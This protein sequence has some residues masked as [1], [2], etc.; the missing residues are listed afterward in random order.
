[1]TCLRDILIFALCI[2]LALAPVVS[3][4]SGPMTWEGSV[5]TGSLVVKENS[6][7]VAEKEVLTFDI[8][9]FP[10]EYYSTESALQEYYGAT[11]T[12]EYTFRNP[13]DADVTA[14][15]LFPYGLMPD[16][17]NVYAE[18][19]AGAMEFVES[20]CGVWADGEPL[21]VLRRASLHGPGED[22]DISEAERLHGSFMDHEFY[23][24]D[25]TVTKYLY[26]VSGVDHETYGAADWG[27][28]LRSDPAL[29]KILIRD[30]DGWGTMEDHVLVHG[31]VDRRTETDK[32][33][34]HVIG[35]PFE[36]QPEW[37]VYENGACEKVIDGTVELIHTETMTLLE[38][39]T[40]LWQDRYGISVTDWYNAFIQ[41]LSRREFS[42]GCIEPDVISR[43]DLASMYWYQYELTIPAGE[44]VVNTVTAP[45]YPDI[46]KGW[47]PAIYTYQYLLSPAKGWADFGS[48]DIV[49]KT[50]YYMTQCNLDGFEKT[51]EGYTL[52]LEGLPDK[53]LE[54]VLCYEQDP[55]R[56]G[57]RGDRM[58]LFAGAA[59]AVLIGGLLVRMGKRGKQNR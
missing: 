30:A 7:I 46:H 41:D 20:L 48:L 5:G 44:T 26:E 8:R 1:M 43:V 52:H 13:T 28:E 57:S 42:Q 38:L 39:S 6:P 35:E 34:V 55:A 50:P 17:V 47:D 9:Q 18:E 45:L 11:V 4:N 31:G 54:F 12:A 56:P 23:R 21:E 16:Y 51:A 37:V 58:L 36:A 3:A 14:T 24:P 59:A 53:E 19:H 49:V 27:A 29:R 25:M 40:E 10:A 32:F 2:L 15:L 22:F 33:A